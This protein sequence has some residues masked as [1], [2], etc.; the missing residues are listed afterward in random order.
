M[1]LIWLHRDIKLAIWSIKWITI[2]LRN[3]S[4]N[5]ACRLRYKES[6]IFLRQVHRKRHKQMMIDSWVRI[7]SLCRATIIPRTKTKLI[8]K[9]AYQWNTKILLILI[10]LINLLE[11]NIK[12]MIPKVV[13]SQ[14]FIMK[15]LKVFR[16]ISMVF[17]RN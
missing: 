14:S 16:I 3:I 7:I 4:I 13:N 6:K 5:L 8:Y 17:V 11:A 9:V 12:I 1:K 2:L 10:S 15:Y